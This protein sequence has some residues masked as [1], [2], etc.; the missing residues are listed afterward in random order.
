MRERKRNRMLGFDYSTEAVYF[1]TSC[2][3]DRICHF[4]AVENNQM[5]LNT[6]GKIAAQQIQ[7]LP[8]QYPYL[9]LH[10]YVVMPNHVHVLL[11]INTANIFGNDNVGNGRDHSLHYN[12]QQH[13]QQHFQQQPK[14]PI[15]IKSI[16]E[17]MGAFKTTSS[18]LIHLAGNQEFKWQKSFYDHIIKNNKSYDNI[19]NYIS[20]NPINWQNDTLNQTTM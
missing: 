18:K 6:F 15:K 7:W 8:Q 2:C 4:G 14:I 20:N 12:S 16:S 5:I 10:N 3:Q 1:L 9:V 17:L 11:E 13:F 19:Y